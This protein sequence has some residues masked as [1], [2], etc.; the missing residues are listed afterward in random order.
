MPAADAAQRLVGCESLDPRGLCRPADI[1]AMC[2]A[3]QCFEID[4]PARAVYV[5]T[6]RNGVVWIDAV[7]GSGDIDISGALDAAVMAQGRAKGLRSVAFQTKR[8]GLV[9]KAVQR[10][11]RVAGWILS[12]DL[13]S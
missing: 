12:K 3:G 4:G 13:Q 11:Y 2:Q 8:R 1:L 7:K 5:L 9:Q 10:G 6:V